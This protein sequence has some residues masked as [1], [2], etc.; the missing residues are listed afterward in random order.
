M[1]RSLWHVLLL[2]LSS[3]LHAQD[4]TVRGVVNVL[5]HSKNKSGSADVVIWLTN[6][7]TKE[8]VLLEPPRDCSHTGLYRRLRGQWKRWL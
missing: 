1:T 7:Q 2:V 3:F 5:H 4:A 8:T 6:A